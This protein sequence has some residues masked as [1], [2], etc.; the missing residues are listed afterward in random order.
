MEL[1]KRWHRRA[2]AQQKQES[3]QN[4]DDPVITP[5]KRLIDLWDWY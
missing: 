4:P 2:R 1:K 5:M 3:L